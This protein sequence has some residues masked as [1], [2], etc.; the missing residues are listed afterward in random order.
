MS[1]I[2]EIIQDV[3]IVEIASDGP[4]G[5]AGTNGTNGA[6]ATIAAGTT[7]T[8]AAG[9]SATVANSGTS[10]AAVFNFGIPQGAK[11]NT[12]DKGDK[13]DAGSA[14]TVA[15][16][17]TTTLAAGTSATVANSGSSSAA[18]FNFGIPQGAAGNAATATAGTTTTL[19]AG[20]SAT[21]TNV[22]TSSAAVF[23]FGIPQGA[24][25]TNGQGVPTGGS[26]GQVLSKI[27]STDYNTQW[28]NQSGGG[29][30]RAYEPP[31]YVT[32]RLYS[33]LYNSLSN[34]SQ[35]INT[36]RFIPIYIWEDANFD[37]MVISCNS[38]YSGSMTARLGI[39]NNGSDNLPSTVVLDAGTV[40]RTG[41]GSA[42]VEITINQT[43]TK[44]W[45]WLGLNFTVAASVNSFTAILPSATPHSQFIGSPQVGQSPWAS[46]TYTAT[47]GF[48]TAA[49]DLSA[50]TIPTIH[51]RKS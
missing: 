34:A 11:G 45:Y 33:T 42:S 3:T 50:A 39:F 21:V 8:L 22:G 9:T 51:L 17:T 36:T 23:N 32:G 35:T 15:A 6:A 43:L 14:A 40:S 10:S 44:G 20:S 4:Q 46:Q 29:S 41:T 7:T 27:N 38:T 26:A 12:G 13:G 5:P 24:A 49:A 19:S 25:G 18:V 31:A 28:V 37:R 2:I 1:D 47:S 48:A 16:G 30:T